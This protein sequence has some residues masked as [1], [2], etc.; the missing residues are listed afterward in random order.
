MKNFNVLNEYGQ[1]KN[2]LKKLF[3][4]P[5]FSAFLHWKDQHHL[6]VAT[7]HPENK[8]QI[9]EGLKYM[10]SASIRNR[11]LGSKK[12]FSEKE[13][14]YFTEFDGWNHYAIGMEE[15][16]GGCRGIAVIRIVRSSECSTDGEIAITVIDEYQQK[17]IGS[18]LLE[19]IIL[20]ALERDFKRLSFT[21]LPQN[22]ALQRLVKR[23]GKPIQ[24]PQ[25]HDYTQIFVDLSECN[26]DEIK[27][28][29]AAK[30]PSLKNY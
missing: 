20:A 3:F 30:I 21:F 24:G 22:E 2:K 18:F 6:R 15:C 14:S 25:G 28:K 10:S 1:R 12:A 26:P 17:G 8:K 9:S 27:R 7:I 29:L 23:C 13:L 5:E 16:N 11:F 19:L 4:T